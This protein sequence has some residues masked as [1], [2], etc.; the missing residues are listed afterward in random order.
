MRYL[1]ILALLIQ[2]VAAQTDPSGSSSVRV[3]VP[4]PANAA[5]LRISPELA[6]QRLIEAINVDGGKSKIEVTAIPVRSADAGTADARD[7]N[8]L[9]IV[10]VR[11]EQNYSAAV[12]Y[13]TPFPQTPAAAQR[14][15][16]SGARVLLN[17]SIDRVDNDNPV[18]SGVIP[19]RMNADSDA[20][21][22]HAMRNLS[23]RVVHQA[24]KKKH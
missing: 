16:D 9:Y 10:N 24:A 19:L 12:P 18:D 8:C 23:S 7:Q 15:S 6:R 4:T 13:Q 20:E 5:Q 17:Y 22:T 3:C 21:V 1:A 11:F 2:L 14:A